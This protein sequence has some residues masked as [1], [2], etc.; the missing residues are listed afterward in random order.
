MSTFCLHKYL[1]NFLCRHN[2]FPCSGWLQSEHL[3]FLWS[4]LSYV[5]SVWKQLLPKNKNFRN[6]DTFASFKSLLVSSLYKI[7][8]KSDEQ[9]LRYIKKRPILAHIWPFNPV[10]MDTRNFLKNPALSL[11]SIYGCLASCIKSE[12]NN[13]LILRKRNN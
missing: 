1:V 4:S 12:K 7:L 2:F 6:D 5:V 3:L 13:D 9:I 8:K 11:F 10:S